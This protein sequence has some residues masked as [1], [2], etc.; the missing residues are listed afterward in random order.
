M[1]SGCVRKINGKYYI[2]ITDD[3]GNQTTRSVKKELGL[4]RD[5]TKGEADKLLAKKLNELD[6]SGIAYDS[7]ITLADFL[8]QWLEAKE[9]DIDPD[10]LAG[11]KRDIRL[12]VLPHI[13][14]IQLNKLKK[15][16][17]QKYVN[18]LTKETGTRTVNYTLMILRQALSQAVEWELLAKNPADKLM[19]ERYEAPEKIIWTD[20][21]FSRFLNSAQTS[22]FYPIYILIITTG[23]RRGEI[24]AL[25]WSDIDFETNTISIT[26]SLNAER[27]IKKPKTPTSVRNLIIPDFVADILRDH[28][29][30]QKKWY[31]A[32]GIR[33]ETDAVFTTTNGTYLFPRNVLRAFKQDCRDAG[34]PVVDLHSLRHLHVSV[35]LNEGVDIKRIQHQ[36]GHAKPSTT[37]NVYSHLINKTDSSVAEKIEEHIQKIAVQK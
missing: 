12:H 10:T 21:E 6:D 11:Y 35:L 18:T 30:Q 27:I 36:V 34:V 33:P 19:Y 32:S 26:K 28:H 25:E 5:A 1:A 13:G 29:K 24:L 2:K 14:T 22:R 37:V 15:I 4:S 7:K 8:D 20:E 3:N 17:L 16:T 23:M 9:H 31:M